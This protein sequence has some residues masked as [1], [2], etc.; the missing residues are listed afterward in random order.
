MWNV[1]INNWD[2]GLGPIP[3]W[4]VASVHSLEVDANA[5][6]ARY[7]ANNGINPSD[8]KVVQAS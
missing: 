4:T 3:G 7:I 8:I 6:M 1:E 5:Q 2:Q